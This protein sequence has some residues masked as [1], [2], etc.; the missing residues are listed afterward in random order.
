MQNDISVGFAVKTL[1]NLFKRHI[2]GSDDHLTGMQGWIIG[3]IYEHG[4]E[5]DIYQRDIESKFNI[6]RSTV[7][8]ILQLMEKSGLLIRRPVPSD[9]RLKKLVLTDKAM[10]M[11]EQFKRRAAEIDSLAAKGLS[12]EELDCFFKIADKMI[13]NLM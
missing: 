10:Q 1:S 3:Y 2:S 4:R 9:A 6:R 7:T 12:K 11:H 8:G 5:I 13:K